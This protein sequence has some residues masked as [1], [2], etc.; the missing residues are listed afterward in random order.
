MVPEPQVSVDG[1][2]E[3][4]PPVEPVVPAPE[5]ATDCGLL[6]AASVKVR[7]ALRLPVVAGLKWIVA[8]QLAAVARLEPHVILEI[9]KSDALGPETAMLLTV[10]EAAVPL[11][12][13]AVSDVPPELRSILPKERLDGLAVTPPVEPV[14]IPEREVVCGLFVTVSVKLRVA[15]RDPEAAG[16]NRM[17]AVQLAEA[18]R[19]ELQVFE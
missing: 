19:V 18:A 11:F 1:L 12:K 2:I 15:V 4:L 13:V 16:L 14:P 5:S 6:L 9:E 17:V 7:V 3:M 10:I 8:V